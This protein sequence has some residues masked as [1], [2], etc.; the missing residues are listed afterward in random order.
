[1]LKD[2][3]TASLGRLDGGRAAQLTLL[4]K[5]QSGSGVSGSDNRKV[6]G[7]RLFHVNIMKWKK[8]LVSINS[9]QHNGNTIQEPS[10]SRFIFSLKN[11]SP[12]DGRVR[13]LD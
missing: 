9:S 3:V 12:G 11:N 5:E 6:K 13:S 10:T 2:R 1:M 4:H 8:N 7:K